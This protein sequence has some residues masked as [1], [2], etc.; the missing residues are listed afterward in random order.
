MLFLLSPA[1]S[2]DF[3]PVAVDVPHTEPLF[4]KHSAK[5][6]KVL[7]AKAPQEIASLMDLSDKLSGVVKQVHR[8]KRQAGRAGV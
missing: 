7:K 8:Q 6:I 5:L 4:V 3:E 1:K 2:L